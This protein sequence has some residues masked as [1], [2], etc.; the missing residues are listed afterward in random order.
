MH[1]NTNP[2]NNHRATTFDPDWYFS[3][4]CGNCGNVC[5]EKRADRKENKRLLVESGVVVLNPDGTREAT[6]G[7]ILEIQ[8]PY[9]VKVAISK[10]EFEKL[11]SGDSQEKDDRGFTPKDKAVL[12]FIKKQ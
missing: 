6:H 1:L 3:A 2:Y 8:T 9:E 12:S 5:W 10:Q 11:K 7:A 4:A